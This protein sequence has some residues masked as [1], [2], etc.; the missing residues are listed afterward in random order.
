MPPVPYTPGDL[1]SVVDYSGFYPLTTVAI[2]G[3][4]SPCD[5]SNSILYVA[6]QRSY[7]DSGSWLALPSPD[8]VPVTVQLPPGMIAQQANDLVTRTSVPI[9]STGDGQVIVDIADNPVALSVIPAQAI[10][11]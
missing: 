1:P 8:P 10:R 5:V 2:V 7:P 3:T 9:Y 6:W 11:P 4:Q